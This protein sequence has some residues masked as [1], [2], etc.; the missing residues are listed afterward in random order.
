MK[1][2]HMLKWLASAALF[3][4]IFTPLM[5]RADGGVGEVTVTNHTKHGAWITIYA[6]AN[7][8]TPWTIT[9]MAFCLKA[10]ARQL[11]PIQPTNELKVRAEI[12]PGADCAWN[13]IWD[14]YDVR[15]GLTQKNIFA[16]IYVNGDHYNLWF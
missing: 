5:A 3:A 16:G 6:S 1:G 10:D 7:V 2:L 11:A 13:T 12:K 15:K 4:S 14:T 8:F 9:G